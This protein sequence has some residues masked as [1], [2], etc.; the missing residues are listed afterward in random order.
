MPKSVLIGGGPGSDTATGG[1]GGGSVAGRPDTNSITGATASVALRRFVIREPS[2]K[3]AEPVV[4]GQVQVAE[5]ACLPELHLAN[6]D[7]G[8]SIVRAVT[9]DDDPEFRLVGPD[10]A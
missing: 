9:A 1:G 6:T 3:C 5:A 8:Q 2:D 10:G 4:K 7:L